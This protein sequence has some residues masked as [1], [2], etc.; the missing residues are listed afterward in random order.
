MPYF[1]VPTDVVDDHSALTDWA[2]QSVAVARA[3]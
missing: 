2:S 1:A 3:G